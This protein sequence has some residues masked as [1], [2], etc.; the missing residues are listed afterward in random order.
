[1]ADSSSTAS[2]PSMDD[3]LAS[4]RRIIDQDEQEERDASS[5][6]N[7]DAGG[8]QLFSFAGDRGDGDEAGLDS[9]SETVFPQ[10]GTQR[11][12][13]AAG[14]EENDAATGSDIYERAQTRLEAEQNAAQNKVD[15]LL[16]D[17]A[18]DEEDAPLDLVE[19]VLDT[20][21]EF[22]GRVEDAQ[23]GSDVVELRQTIDDAN[24][25]PPELPNQIYDL[26]TPA[27]D[28]AGT[29]QASSE[30]SAAS[31]LDEMFAVQDS[32][33]KP[34]EDSGEIE[35]SADI[36]PKEGGERRR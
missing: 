23:T 19:R 32:S 3:I 2:E 22:G 27:A 9:G 13:R 14:R 29:L 16:R 7:G 26:T 34:R 31:G 36:H 1:M 18:D 4:I 30:G 25:E 6:G 12:S 20:Q 35:E 10:R 33:Q 24:F 28:D 15:E 11:W 5:A 8:A 21:T 17:H